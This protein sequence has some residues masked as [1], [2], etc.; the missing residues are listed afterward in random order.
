MIRSLHTLRDQ[1]DQQWFQNVWVITVTT[2]N[3]QLGE[4]FLHGWTERWD[5]SQYWAACSG[6]VLVT[7]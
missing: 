7:A 4:A 6:P 3:V 2:V 5:A 1:P